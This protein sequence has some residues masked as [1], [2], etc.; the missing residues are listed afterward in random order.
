VL[1]LRVLSAS[2]ILTGLVGLLYA[3]YHYAGRVPGIWL[4]PCAILVSQLMARELLDLWRDRGDRPIPW[5]MYA[6]VAMPVVL[7][8]TPWWGSLAGARDVTGSA[9]WA[10]AGVLM[11]IA[12]LF[13][14]EMQRFTQPGPATARLALSTLAIIYAGWLVSFLVSLRLWHEARWGMAALVSVIIVVKLAD[15]GAYFVGRAIGRHRLAP[16]LSP[17]K[18][19]EGLGG[20]LAAAWLGGVLCHAWVVP[21]LVGASDGVG[22]RFGWLMYATVLT[23]AGLCGDLAESLL[24]RDAGRKDSSAWL[25]GLG[26][27]LDLA[28]SL[29]FAAPAAYACW[30]AGLI[31]PH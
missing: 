7:A 18:T 29:L 3:D 16:V 10:A 14:S 26:G 9:A 30:V 20:G 17:K 2:V 11:A 27:V 22:S 5:V 6:G 21:Q 23:I 19:W 28:D 31:G 1:K 12:L 8:A 25:P 4:L 15:T 13:A 24:K